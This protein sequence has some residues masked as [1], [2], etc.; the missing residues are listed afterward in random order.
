MKATDE[1]LACLKGKQIVLISHDLS[2]T[3]SPLLLVETAVALRQA[4]ALVR[5]V[6]LADHAPEGNVAAR[7]DIDMLPIEH[8]FEQSARADLVIAN[9]AETSSWVD[10]YLKYHPPGGRALIWWIHEIDASFYANRMHSL[11]DVALALFDS[12]ASLKN[13]TD[14]GLG[15]PPSAKVIYPGVDDA[16]IQRADRGRFPLPRAGI[17]AKLP[18][19]PA[20]HDRTAIRRN[21]GVEP[22]DFVVTLIGTYQPNKGHDLFVD[23][24]G[25]LLSKNPTLPIKVIV[26]G[27][28]SRDDAVKV[29]QALSGAA[30]KALDH[31]RAVTVVEDLTP[32]YAASDAFVMNSQGLGENFG[33]VTVE[34][35]TFRLPLLG[36]RAAGTEEIVEDGVTGL[37]HPVGRDGQDE[38]AANILALMSSREEARAMGEAGYRRVQERFTS[39]RFYGEL[40]PLLGAILSGKSR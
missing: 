1:V 40:G 11:P 39:Q 33:R 23:T 18:F 5:L 27:F 26:V 14:T 9:T 12:Y 13:W 34:A 36:T 7:N 29:V 16:F 22:N 6:S 21:L 30:R 24:I 15:F 4:G 8:S 25:R 38:L 37:L 19:R 35:M 17:F 20:T 2:Q 10:R 28:C 32:Y 3:G 31:R